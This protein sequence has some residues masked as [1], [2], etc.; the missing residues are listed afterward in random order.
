MGVWVAKL[1]G[2]SNL[3]MIIQYALRAKIYSLKGRDCLLKLPNRF[4]II[5]NPLRPLQSVL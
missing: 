2:V 1:S 3:P 5:E 4:C